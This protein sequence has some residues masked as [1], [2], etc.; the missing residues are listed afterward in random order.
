MTNENE[1]EI[2]A[3]TDNTIRVY[4]KEKEY[5]YDI[6]HCIFQL[7]ELEEKTS[8]EDEY[9]ILLTA[10]KKDNMDLY[11]YES[12]MKYN[13]FKNSGNSFNNFDNIKEIF[14][15]LSKTNFF[16][17][18]VINEESLNLCIESKLENFN[19]KFSSNIILL[20]KNYTTK[21]IE[22][23]E[24]NRNLQKKIK[25]LE[26]EIKI[27][28]ENDN[29]NIIKESITLDNHAFMRGLANLISSKSYEI[30]SLRKENNSFRSE[31]ALLRSEN[32]YLRSCIK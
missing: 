10:K 4:K 26:N 19:K 1:N 15:F 21:E 12:N 11:Y 5:N 25:D 22:I 7:K 18:E 20:K 29:K 17:E 16:I 6:Y 8:K 2:Y 32:E 9:Y 14:D 30:V 28:K 24:Q 27:L 23:V 13:D 3:L 31:N